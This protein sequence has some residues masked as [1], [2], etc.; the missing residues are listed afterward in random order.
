[1]SANNDTSAID[2]KKEQQSNSNNDD[3]S[4]K[5]QKFFYPTLVQIIGYVILNFV[6]GSLVLYICKL[7]QS[8][9]LPTDINCYPYTSVKPE[10]G[11]IDINIFV[12]PTKPQKSMKIKFP[13]DEYNSSNYI[14]DFFRK[15]KD[16][17][18]TGKFT[19]YFISIFEDIIATNYGIIN[20]IGNM[21]NGTLHEVLILLF[22]PAIFIVALSLLSFFNNFYL[23][24]LWFNKMTWFF[25][26]NKYEGTDKP[27]KWEEGNP[28]TGYGIM[29]LFIILIF[30]GFPLFF[31]SFVFISA[32]VVLWCLFSGLSYKGVLNNVSVKSPEIIGKVLYYYKALILFFLSI[33]IIRNVF[34]YF[35]NIVGS[36]CIAAFVVFIVFFGKIY[37][38]SATLENVT[39]ITGYEQAKKICNNTSS[40]LSN[41]LSPLE[42]FSTAK[43]LKD[44]E[45]LGTKAFQDKF[46]IPKVPKIEIPKV[47]KIEIPTNKFEKL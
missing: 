31:S 45:K 19:N 12:T 34:T 16:D 29:C 11:E 15:K 1:M 9:I 28:I 30:V 20:S 32:F 38:K 46:K 36:S 35:G 5:I 39:E 25:L 26:E 6:L 47:P 27:H 21:L 2:E 10:I 33:G 17:P 24:Y 22:G 18:K 37:L 3:M 4:T 7:S 43:K 13:Y 23:V 14:L 42:L 44:L 8:N 40:N 41:V